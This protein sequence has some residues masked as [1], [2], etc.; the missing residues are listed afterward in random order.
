MNLRQINRNQKLSNFNYK[1]IDFIFEQDKIPSGKETTK[2]VPYFWYKNKEGKTVSSTD[3][4]AQDRGYELAT[5][6]DVAK[7]KGPE[8][9]DTKDDE[10]QPTDTGSQDP[11][12]RDIEAVADFMD[13]GLIK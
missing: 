4:N 12:G 1:L 7:E 2:G 10:T 13:G 11:E 5:K 8:K 9:V 3:Q 6:E